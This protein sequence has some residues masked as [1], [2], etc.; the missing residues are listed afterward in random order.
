MPKE[1]TAPRPA[2]VAE[3]QPQSALLPVVSNVVT[4]PPAKILPRQA[5]QS[6]PALMGLQAASISWPKAGAFLL[7]NLLGALSYFA[8]LAAT[9]SLDVSGGHW[10]LAFAQACVFS[11]AALIAFRF[12]R[13][14]WAAAAIAAFATLL[15]TLPVYGG[16]PGFQWVDLFYREQFQQFILLPFVS[17]FVFL[18]ALA[19]LVPKLQ[20]CVLALWLSAM[21]ADIISALFAALLRGLGAK[22]GPDPVLGSASLLAAICRSLVFAAVWWGPLLYM[23]RKTEVISKAAA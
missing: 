16:L 5:S 18:S 7:A 11:L 17:G 9:T 3:P 8:A 6:F 2:I 23:G 14:P 22:E 15:L 10:L 4:M 21:S 13:N 12:I 19:L 20:P 1:V